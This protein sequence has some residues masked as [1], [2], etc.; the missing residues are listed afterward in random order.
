MGHDGVVESSSSAAR[1][2]CYD[3]LAFKRGCGQVYD[4]RRR[5]PEVFQ[6]WEDYLED[7]AGFFRVREWQRTVVLPEDD[8]ERWTR[9]NALSSSRPAAPASRAVERS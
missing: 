9:L 5:C 7:N 3:N 6:E 2:F 1:R 4:F 8:S